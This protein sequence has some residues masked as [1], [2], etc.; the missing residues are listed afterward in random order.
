MLALDSHR[1]YFI[2]RGITDMRKG[3]DGL[4]GLVRNELLRDPLTDDVYLFFNRNK[5]QVRILT[6]D[7]DGFAIY[8]KRLE[9]GTFEL[10]KGNEISLPYTTLLFILSGVSLSSVRHRKRYVHQGVNVD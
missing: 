9:K 6:W 5:K 8:G 4:S 3:F 2:Y 7:N 10:P 1:R